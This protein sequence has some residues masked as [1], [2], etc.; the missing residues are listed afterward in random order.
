MKD[1]NQLELKRE[2]LFKDA[3]LNAAEMQGMEII[4]QAQRESV[5][6]LQE[7]Q[8]AC[9]QV[10]RGSVQ[11]TLER[12]SRRQESA[13]MQQ[14]RQGLLRHRSQLVDALF[15]QVEEKLA[16]FVDGKDYAAWLEKKLGQRTKGAA[17]GAGLTVWLRPADMKLEKVV[18]KVLP[19]AQVQADA[20]IRIGGVRVSDG[21]ILYDDT[22]DDALRAEQEAFTKSGALGL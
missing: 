7:A 20:D 19:G 16:A 5:K 18:K 1:F 10:D 21:Y 4:A 11:A 14:A 12:D 8:A 6:T 13:V 3:V 22:L 17:D 2:T 9:Q 15:A